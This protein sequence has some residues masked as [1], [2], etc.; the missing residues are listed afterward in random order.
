MIIIVAL[1]KLSQ[2]LVQKNAKVP[3]HRRATKYCDAS[4]DRESPAIC[5][6]V[7][8]PKNKRIDARCGPIYEL[9]SVR[10]VQWNY[11]MKPSRDVKL[12]K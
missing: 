5:L 10:G 8:A 3:Y 11:G 1:G 4:A 6:E 7:T 2:I 12:R 9:I